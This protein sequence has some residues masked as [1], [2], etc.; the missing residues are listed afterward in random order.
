MRR[1][2]K[3][4]FIRSISVTIGLVVF[5]ILMLTNIS[6]SHTEVSYKEMSVSSGDTLWSI[7]KYEKYNNVYF[8]DKDIRDIVDEIKYINKLNNSNL[9]IGDMLTIPTIIK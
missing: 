3:K 6:F 2:N 1:L 9:N 5:I 4:K 7:A 8:E